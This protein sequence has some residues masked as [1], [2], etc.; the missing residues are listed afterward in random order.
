LNVKNLRQYNRFV[1]DNAI[2]LVCYFHKHTLFDAINTIR[3]ISMAVV[4]NPNISVNVT[5]TEAFDV[6]SGEI[7]PAL[8]SIDDTGESA[9][10]AAAK[11]TAGGASS[12]A[13]ITPRLPDVSDGDWRLRLSVGPSSGIF[14]LNKSPGILAPLTETNGVVFPYVPQVTLSYV[15]T[16]AA[17]T[18]VHSINS[19]QSYQSSDVSSIQITS[20]FTAQ[21]TDEAGYV[22]AVI[23]FFKSASKMFFGGADAGS[24]R[25]GSPPPILFLNGMGTHYFP[26]VPVILTSFSHTFTD[27]V[28]FVQALTPGNDGE[29]GA[30]TM[31]PTVSS[32]TLNLVPQYSRTIVRGFNLDDFARGNLVIGGNFRGFI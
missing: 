20:E 29:P 14:Y 15:N 8:P 10:L 23:H 5:Q 9:R 12:A 4:P 1:L 2:V 7:F 30:I 27:S 25:A 26:N 13:D 22:L 17:T 31:V 19:I 18:P 21:T 32:I 28:D 3:N 16:Y 11:L 6:V 24:S